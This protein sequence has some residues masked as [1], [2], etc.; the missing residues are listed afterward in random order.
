MTAQGS[1]SLAIASFLHSGLF[2]PVFTGY[3]RFNLSYSFHSLRPRL[4]LTLINGT[5]KFDSTLLHYTFPPLSYHSHV[6]TLT[7]EYTRVIFL[8]SFYYSLPR[9]SSPLLTEYTEV[10]FPCKLILPFSA[11]EFT[12][13]RGIHG[14]Q[15]RLLH[16]LSLIH[17]YIELTFPCNQ[18]YFLLLYN[19]T[20]MPGC[21]EVIFVVYQF[22]L[23]SSCFIFALNVWVQKAYIY[24]LVTL[25]SP[26]LTYLVFASL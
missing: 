4:F 8:Y 15:F 26:P 10:I 16:I 5:H 13:I 19:V 6:F 14:D 23:L 9:P 12:L 22:L 11:C 25:N 1:F 18:L 17:I 24:F 2:S 20:L 21:T 3:V 7:Y